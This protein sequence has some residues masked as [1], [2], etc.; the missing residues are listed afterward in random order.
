MNDE[1]T[2]IW[3]TGARIW[4]NSKGQ[5]HRDNG[6]PAVI[7]SDGWC[8]WY[9]NNEKLKEKGCTKEEVEEYRKPYYKQKKFDIKFNRFEN[10]I[11]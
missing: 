6:L 9:Q 1:P 11:K 5:C 10:L 2:E 7:F 3:A 4:K 8:Q